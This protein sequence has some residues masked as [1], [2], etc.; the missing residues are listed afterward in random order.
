VKKVS[1]PVCQMESVVVEYDEQ[2]LCCI[3][4]LPIME[5]SMGGTDVCPWCDCGCNRDGSRWEFR[6]LITKTKNSYHPP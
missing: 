5:A 6:E 1:Y 3:C 4:G 2:A